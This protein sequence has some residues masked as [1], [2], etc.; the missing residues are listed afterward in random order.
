MVIGAGQ[1]TQVLD[2]VVPAFHR[3][4]NQSMRWIRV[5]WLTILATPKQVRTSRHRAKPHV[6]VLRLYSLELRR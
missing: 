3:T 6:L 4:V 1:G 5:A 2:V